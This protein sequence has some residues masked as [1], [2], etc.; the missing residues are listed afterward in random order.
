MIVYFD[1]SVFISVLSGDATAQQVRDLL[2]ELQKAKIR[3]YT[4]IITIQEVSVDCFKNGTIATDNHALVKKLARI[5]G[6]TRDV[7]VTAAKLEA[8]ILNGYGSAAEKTADNKRRKWD[9]FHIATAQC[10][11]CAWLYSFDEGM[12]RR[13]SRL[14]IKGVQFSKP[15]PLAAGL[16]DTAAD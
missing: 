12:L 5:E 8:Q 10:L 6:I 13:E 14:N 2:Q 7:A 3:I 9:C 4:S 16:F 11:K 1:S 15:A